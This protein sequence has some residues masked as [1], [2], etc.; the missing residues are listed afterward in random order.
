MSVGTYEDLPFAPYREITSL[1]DE[2]LD[3]DLWL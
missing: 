3:V 1:H 2:N